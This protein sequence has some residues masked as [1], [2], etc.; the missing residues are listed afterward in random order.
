MNHLF[1]SELYKLRKDPIFQ[2][3]ML[4][5][6]T[7]PI[8]LFVITHILTLDSAKP[9]MTGM[10]SFSNA[11]QVNQLLLK[12]SLGIW[13]GFFISKEY[14]SGVM[15]VTSSSGFTRKRIY[16]AKLLAFTLGIVF[17]SLLCPLIYIL[18]GTILNGFGSLTEVAAAEYLF[19]TLSLTVLFAA[20]FAAIVAV[21]G[22]YFTEAGATIGIS[23]LFF[24]FFD[25]ISESLAGRIPVYKTFYD[26]SVFKL[27]LQSF[28]YQMTGEAILLSIG[29]AILTFAV[30][31]VW[32]MLVFQRKEIK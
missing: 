16:T 12:I 13:A 9:P 5:M 1:S 18:L 4:I 23:L 11:V 27:F 19:R 30:F 3:L 20:A 22:I 31:A 6:I 26:H 25:T 14:A 15:K 8:A 32:G 21:L 28:E 29:I 2:M 10:R 24:L 17:L 7:T